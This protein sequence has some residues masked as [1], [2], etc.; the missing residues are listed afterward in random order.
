MIE[1]IYFDIPEIKAQVVESLSPT[2]KPFG[3]VLYNL[4]MNN[5]HW[6]WNFGGKYTQFY[7]KRR[8]GWDELNSLNSIDEY[9]IECN[10]NQIGIKAYNPSPDTKKAECTL[11]IILSS[12]NTGDNKEIFHANNTQNIDSKNDA[13]FMLNIYDLNMTTF[14]LKSPLSYLSFEI[15]ISPIFMNIK[16]TTNIFDLILKITR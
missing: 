9:R 15:S 6:V 12:T 16:S 1:K 7:Y 14:K 2:T 5:T 13:D 4:T 11:R 10:Q 8:V 3:E